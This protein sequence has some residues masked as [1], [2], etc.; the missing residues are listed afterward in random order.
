M[1]DYQYYK[2]ALQGIP[3]PYAF[4]DRDVLNENIH[5]ILSR[6]KGKSIR[7]ASKSIRSIGILRYI[8]Q[9]SPQF[10][11]IMCYSPWEAIYLAKQ[12]FQ[13]LLLGYPVWDTTA[14]VAV[15]SK[16]KEDSPITFMVDCLDHV[17]HIEGIAE[18]EDV[19]IPLCV[20]LDMSSTMFGLHF[21]VH[22]SPLRTTVQALE[23]FKY[24]ASSRY[25]YLDGIMGYEAQIAGLGDRYPSQTLK[26]K[27]VRFL[28]E[29]SIHEVVQ[30]RSD[31]VREV[32]SLGIPYRFINGGGTGSLRTTTSEEAVT[33]VTVGSGFYAPGLFDNYQDFR[34]QPALGF[35]IEIVRI[36]APSIY[37]CLGGGYVASGATGN[38]KLPK[39]Y[40][41]QEATLLKNEGAGEVQTPIMYKGEESLQLGD[42]IFMRHSKAGELCERF[43][44]L[45]IVS[46]GKVMD[47]VTTYR[48]DGACFL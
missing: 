9:A 28:K 30:R 37:T 22:R 3:L 31:I 36:P 14:I 44:H 41:P 6:S 20:D 47:K 18:K 42:P 29:R 5:D 2:S 11:G 40:L 24:I 12:G 21:G 26:N 45:L 16:L 33:E 1:R 8:F 25:V 7:L 39:P 15:T 34:Y 10:Q 4:L 19:L 48:G 32:R 43:T 46:E 27:I 17:K 23:V 35:A 38:D 13:D